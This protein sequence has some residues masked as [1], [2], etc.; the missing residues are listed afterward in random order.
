MDIP[1]YQTVEYIMRY[2]QFRT[3]YGIMALSVRSGRS[4]PKVLNQKAY[5]FGTHKVP[6]LRFDGILDGW[7]GIDKEQTMERP[8]WNVDI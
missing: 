6:T 3:S 2:T 5:N 4:V 8:F 7:Q 1:Y